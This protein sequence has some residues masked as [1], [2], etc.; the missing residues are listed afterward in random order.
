MDRKFSKIELSLKKD[1]GWTASPGFRIAA[2]DRGAIRFEFPRDW[3]CIPEEDSV[4][5]YDCN[6]P[7]DNCRLA[8]SNQ[9]RL[10]IAN[11]VPLD[12]LLTALAHDDLRGLHRTMEV[13][14]QRKHSL[15]LAWVEFQFNDSQL[16][17]DARSRFCVARGSGICALVTFEFWQDDIDQFEPVWEHLM[18]TITLGEFILDPTSG[19]R[20]RRNNPETG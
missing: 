14:H 18:K 2:I 4:K 6:P 9:R 12:E 13:V 19:A 7:A 17:H 5:F 16:K 8:V 15:E 10:E 20:I 3:I 11:R 1:H